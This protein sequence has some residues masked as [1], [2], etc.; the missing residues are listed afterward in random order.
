[1]Q[2]CQSTTS[3]GRVR[4]EFDW[5]CRRCR[6][7]QHAEQELSEFFAEIGPIVPTI[8][9]SCADQIR[10]EDERREFEAS[11][12]ARSLKDGVPPGFL[13]YDKGRGNSALFS[14]IKENWEKSLL[15]VGKVDTGKS[16]AMAYAFTRWEAAQKGLKLRFISWADFCET[17]AALSSK[18]FYEAES[19]KNGILGCDILAID[20][21]GKRRSTPI[22]E[23]LAYSVVNSFYESGRRMWMTANKPLSEI[24]QTFNN[25]DIAEAVIS[26]FDRMIHD[27]IMVRWLELN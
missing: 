22:M 21:F 11:W 24:L 14:W 19:F 20:D 13:D 17:Y 8:C 5:T 12:R 6:K 26:R 15:I 18:N 9:D 16:R 23:D 10:E 2:T 27:G 4:F 1:M 3:D 25:Q 7:T